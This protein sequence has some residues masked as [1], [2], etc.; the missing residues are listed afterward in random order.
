MVVH[1]CNPSTWKAEEG[2][3]HTQGKPGLYSETLSERKRK[4]KRRKRRKRVGGKEGKR[5][6]RKEGTKGGREGEGRRE[7]ENLITF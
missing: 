4:R 7:I 2:E 3:S 5:K 6:G 1:V